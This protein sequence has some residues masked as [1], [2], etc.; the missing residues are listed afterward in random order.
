M[1]IIKIKTKYLLLGKTG[2]IFTVLFLSFLL[3]WGSV[4]ISFFNFYRF[5]QSGFFE[6]LLSRYNN[7]LLYSGFFAAAFIILFSNLLF[8]SAIRSGEQKYFFSQAME[9]D[10][11]ITSLFYFIGPKKSFKCFSFYCRLWGMKLFWY[12]FF[13]S[14]SALCGAMIYYLYSFTKLSATALVILISG[15]ILLFSAGLFMAGIAK[16]RYCAAPLFFTS[17]K[18]SAKEAIDKSIILS[19]GFL[20]DFS[21]LKASFFP[22]FLSCAFILP[23]FYALPYYR[24]CSAVFVLKSTAKNAKRLLKIPT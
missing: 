15:N 24:L 18:L 1:G 4:S 2:K 13:L 6:T 19:D 23:I 22:W 5:S 12:V 9:K 11:K 8:G 3:R 16:S 17:E 7:I 14:P 10:F 21:R 20:S